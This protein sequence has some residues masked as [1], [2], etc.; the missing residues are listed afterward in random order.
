MLA[1]KSFS[2]LGAG[3]THSVRVRQS[4]RSP[5]RPVCH[6]CQG[7]CTSAPEEHWKHGDQLCLRQ[8]RPSVCCVAHRLAWTGPTGLNRLDELV[9]SQ[10]HQDSHAEWGTVPMPVMA[11]TRSCW[12]SQ[13]GSRMEPCFV[14]QMSP[15]SSAVFAVGLAQWPD[16]T[17]NN[18]R[19]RGPPIYLLITLQLCP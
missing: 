16:E 7:R 17:C 1:R 6:P 19:F 14:S 9:F 18:P 10:K 15:R 13:A 12:L 3:A 2:N 11:I 8:T 5:H 4:R